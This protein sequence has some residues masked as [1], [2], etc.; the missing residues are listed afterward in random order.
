M[1]REQPDGDTQPFALDH[2]YR[3]R[4][5]QPWPADSGVG[6]GHGPERPGK[7]RLSTSCSIASN[8]GTLFVAQI[9]TGVRSAAAHSILGIT[10]RSAKD[11][12]RGMFTS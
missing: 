6:A 8:V 1:I 11:P 7:L 10:R 2:S 12:R 9:V 5:A 4:Y 3:L